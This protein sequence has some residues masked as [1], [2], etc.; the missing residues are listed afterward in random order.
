MGRFVDHAKKVLDQKVQGGK[1]VNDV[2]HEIQ[3][4]SAKAIKERDEAI[5]V[6]VDRF[7]GNPPAEWHKVIG[8]EDYFKAL[9]REWSEEF[10]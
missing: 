5:K 6:I 2:I 1:K 4:A 9:E 10:E 8:N 3:I 7:E